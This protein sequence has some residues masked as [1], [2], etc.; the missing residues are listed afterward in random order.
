MSGGGNDNDKSNGNGAACRSRRAHGSA[1]AA[2]RAR[3]AP[4]DAC[5]FATTLL[6][7]TRREA[8]PRAAPRIR[9][10]AKYSTRGR[11]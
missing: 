11:Y 1:C 4:F 5:A 3:L 10:R 7:A 2:C 9:A 8:K 6:R